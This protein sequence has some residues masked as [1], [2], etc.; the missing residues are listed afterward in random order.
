MPQTALEPL[1]LHVYNVDSGS[2]QHEMLGSPVSLVF[3]EAMNLILYKDGI[4]AFIGTRSE[5]GHYLTNLGLETGKGIPSCWTSCP[6][7][8]IMSK[9][10]LCQ[11]GETL[12]SREID[13]Y[14]SPLTVTL[15]MIL[16]KDPQVVAWR[17]FTFRL[18]AANG[19][20]FLE[21]DTCRHLGLSEPRMIILNELQE[22]LTYIKTIFM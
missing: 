14:G 13:F 9:L 6:V 20:A 22:A 17:G 2:W 11:N 1:F 12:G 3:L 8:T 10:G 19:F 7:H 16:S 5:F 15:G 18:I 4:L 21:G